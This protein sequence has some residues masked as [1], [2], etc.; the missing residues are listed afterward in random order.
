MSVNADDLV[1]VDEG[2]PLDV[3][4]RRFKEES[5]NAFCVPS[6][7]QGR[8]VVKAKPSA[9][10]PWPRPDGPSFRDHLS[11]NHKGFRALS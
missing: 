6:M 5:E 4:V 8:L 11:R 9:L 10:V 3:E 1:R 2:S 7:P